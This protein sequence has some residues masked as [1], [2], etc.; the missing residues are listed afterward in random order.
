MNG[1]WI[2]NVMFVLTQR[3]LKTKNEVLKDGYLVGRVTIALP[4]TIEDRCR[5]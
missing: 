3:L 2:L 5:A 1:F 4:T